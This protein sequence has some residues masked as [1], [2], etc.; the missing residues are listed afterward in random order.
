[1]DHLICE[2]RVCFTCQVRLRTPS[3]PMC[4]RTLNR[5]IW[6]TVVRGLSGLY[7]LLLLYHECYKDVYF[8][9]I[10]ENS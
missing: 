7:G 4:R 6:I 3:C 10:D 1:M 5:S 2:H 8:G 9:Q